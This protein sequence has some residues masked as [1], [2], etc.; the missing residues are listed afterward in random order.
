[1]KKIV[2]VISGPPG[3]GS[4]TIAKKIAKK[5]RLKFFSVG[6]YYKKLSKEKNQSKAAY[7][8]WHTKFGSSVKLHNY[9]DKVLQ[10]EMARKGNIVIDAKLG[11]HFLK[12]F[13]KFRIWIDVPLKIRA[14]RATKRDNAQLEQTL[15][16]ILDREEIQRR[17][18][19]SMYGFD[20][21]NQKYEADF[22]L[23]S[24]GLTVKETVQKILDFI[25]KYK[26]K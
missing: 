26:E 13:S 20:Y 18:W 8:L 15:K 2:V 24:S 23:D 12:S 1:M 6:L 22:V 3:S 14:E 17:E 21:L 11:V 16:Q 19:L 9:M 7:E 10:K 25:K 4:T 5:L